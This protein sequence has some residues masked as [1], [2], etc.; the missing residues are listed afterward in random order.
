MTGNYS[1]VT[2]VIKFEER[3]LAIGEKTTKARDLYFE[4]AGA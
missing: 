3:D 1:K 2:P 4:W